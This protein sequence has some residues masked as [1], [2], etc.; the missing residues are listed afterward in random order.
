M[1]YNNMFV[2]LDISKLSK[3]CIIFLLCFCDQHC[4]GYRNM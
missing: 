3:S 2:K 4:D 1:L